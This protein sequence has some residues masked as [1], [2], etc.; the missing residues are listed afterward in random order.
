MRKFHPTPTCSSCSSALL[1]H[2]FSQ[3]IKLWNSA[4]AWQ[5]LPL[6]A[7]QSSLSST[8]ELCWGFHLFSPTSSRVKPTGW[9]RKDLLASWSHLEGSS[10]RRVLRSSCCKIFGEFVSSGVRGRVGKASANRG[11]FVLEESQGSTGEAGSEGWK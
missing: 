9:D 1:V 2:L 4:A 3:E 8:R 11:L 5:Q 6:N 10:S 7:K